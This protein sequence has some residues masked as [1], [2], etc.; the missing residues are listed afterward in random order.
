MS[1]FAAYSL[2]MIAIVAVVI[3]AA[4][5]QAVEPPRPEETEQW[6]PEP[7]IVTPGP[8]NSPSPPSDAIVLLGPKTGLREWSAMDGAEAHWNINKDGSVTV[9]KKAGNIQTRRKFGD[10]Q[11]HLEWR[12]PRGVTGEGQARGNSGLFLAST[13]D[14]DAGYELQILDSYKNKTY[15]NGQAASIYKQSPPLVNSMRPPGQWQSYDVI[16]R[17]PRFRSNGDLA[18]PARVTAFQNGILVQDNFQ[19]AGETAYIGKPGYHQHGRTPI[20]LQA[21]GDPSE[22]LTF[23]NMWVREIDAAPSP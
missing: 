4:S 13:G 1:A 20:K 16:W 14:G 6:S 11:L 22:P 7:R 23:R 17:A 18:A 5:P 12:V 19:L 3:A 2:P 8:A 21:H 9:N 10:Y 15:V